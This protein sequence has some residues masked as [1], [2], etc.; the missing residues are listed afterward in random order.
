MDNNTMKKKVTIVG[1][2]HQG[3]A[4]AAHL[5]FHDVDCYLWNRTE[6]N[7]K[8]IM[9][10]NTIL[11]EGVVEGA[12]HIK[13]VSTDIIECLQKVILVTV[14]SNAHEDIAKML[15]PYVDD[16]FVIVLNPGRTFGARSFVAA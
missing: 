8:A 9:E 6:Q 10:D 11:C 14:P 3:L 12:A 15:A 1:G 4:M 13:H 2:G 5:S 7:I 16:S